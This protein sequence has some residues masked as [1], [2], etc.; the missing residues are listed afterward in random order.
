MTNPNEAYVFKTALVRDAQQAAFDP[1]KKAFDN[2]RGSV[3][4]PM[5]GVLGAGSLVASRWL[6]GPDD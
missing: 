4:L 2:I 6:P 1:A 5:L 3:S